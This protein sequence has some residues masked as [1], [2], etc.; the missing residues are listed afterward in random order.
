MELANDTPGKN[1]NGVEIATSPW[2]EGGSAW[3]PTIE[4]K[5]GK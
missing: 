3:A 4:E 1:E 5:N 2:A